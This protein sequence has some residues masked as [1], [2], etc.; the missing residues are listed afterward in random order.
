MT[1]FRRTTHPE[2][3]WFPQADLGLMLHWGIHSVIS[4]EPSWSMVRD[5]PL[6]RH[7][8]R[9]AYYALAPRFQPDRYDPDKWLAAARAAGFRYAVLT[10]KHHDGYTL[11]PSAFTALGV[12]SHLDGRDLL[13]PYVEACRRHG[14]KVGFYFSPRDWSY[15]GFPPPYVDYDFK[16]GL[17]QTPPFADPVENQA[18]FDQFYAYTR[19]QLQELLT[20]Y[21]R[22]D[23]L[24]FDGVSWPGADIHFLETIQWLRS[25]QPHLVL[26]DRWCQEGG[27]QI[28]DYTTCECAMPETRPEGWWEACT[29]TNGGWGFNH[30]APLPPAA[31]FRE[32]RELCHRWGGNFLPNISPGPDGAMPDSFYPLC[33]ELASSSPNR[34]G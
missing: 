34:K 17:N 8:S 9:E 31:W 15:P 23:L 30:G 18:A 27:E 19:G 26:N 22:I 20:R 24:W 16:L 11:W 5:Y 7:L 28:G 25:L 1:D 4:A 21:G 32:Q 2:A 29:G 33:A 3:Q 14:M 12:H 13:A 10:T 6:E